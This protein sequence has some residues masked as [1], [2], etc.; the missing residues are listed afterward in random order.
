MA[1][2]IADQFLRHR[3]QVGANPQWPLGRP[4]S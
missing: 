4:R 1:C 3:G 2:V